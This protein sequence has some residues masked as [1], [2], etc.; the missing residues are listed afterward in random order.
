MIIRVAWISLFS[1]AFSSDLA[2]HRLN[3]TTH[4]NPTFFCAKRV[5]LQSLQ[6]NK[7]LKGVLFDGVNLVVCQLPASEKSKSCNYFKRTN[8]SILWQYKQQKEKESAAGVIK[9]SQILYVLFFVGKLI[10]HSNHY[11]FLCTRFYISF[12]QTRVTFINQ[13]HVCRRPNHVFRTFILVSHKHTLM[14]SST[15]WALPIAFI[16]VKK[17]SRHSTP[18]MVYIVI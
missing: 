14:P 2:P 8:T 6:R 10:F 5:Y 15:R 9:H 13:A 4:K 1:F 16:K 3:S 12:S 7:I 18:I 11:N 17:Y